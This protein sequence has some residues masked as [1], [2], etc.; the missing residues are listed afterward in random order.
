MK[1]TSLFHALLAAFLLTASVRVHAVD[2]LYDAASTFFNPEDKTRLGIEVE[3]KGLSPEASANEVARVL[4]G[5]VGTRTSTIKTDIKGYGADGKPIYNEF[6]STQYVVKDSS[7]GDVVLK[8]ETNQI[9]DV[10]KIDYDKMIVELIT[11]PIQYPQVEKLEDALKGLE[12]IGAKGTDRYTAVS[13]QVNM[14]M[15][16]GRREDVSV[17]KIL[18]LM[19]A[20][21]RPEHKAQIDAHLKV[22]ALRK[23]YVS[24][25]SDG[26]MKKLLDP[27]YKPTE[28][29]LF[30]DF[31]YRQSMERL[32]D[33]KAWTDPL[34]KVQARFFAHPN[35][36]VPSVVKQNSLRVSSL[37]MWMFP[38]DPVTHLIHDAGWAVP[39]PL[40]EFREWNNTFTAAEPARQA[41]GLKEAAYKYGYFDHDSL[42]QELTG[43]D[44]KVLPK[45]RRHVNADVAKGQPTTFRYYLGDPA[46][47][48][49]AEYTMHTRQAYK[50]EVVGFLN[51][52]GYGTKSLLIPGESVVMHRRPYHRYSVMGK[53]NPGLINANIAQVLE[54]KYAEYRFFNEYAPGSMSRT[55]I[56]SDLT[57]KSKNVRKVVGKLNEKFPK[58]WVLKGVWDLGSEKDIITDKVDVIGEVEKYQASDFDVYRNELLSDKAL[59][60]AA[61]EYLNSE[62]KKHPG[63]KGWKLSQVF[64][65]PE[66]S[67]VQERVN[68]KTE[69]RVEALAGK[70]LGGGSTVDRYSY[71]YLLNDTAGEYK[72]PPKVDVKKVEQFAQKVLDQL[73][74]NLRGMPMGMDIALLEDGTAVMI[75]SNPGGNS[76]FLYEEFEESAEELAKFLKQ[77]PAQVKAGRVHEGLSPEEQMKW[78]DQKFKDWGIHP[79]KQY[80]GFTFLKDRVQDK[81]FRPSPPNPRNYDLRHAPCGLVETIRGYLAPVPALV[82]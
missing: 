25:Y 5:E 9:D 46:T 53:Y 33:K 24:S 23:P 2:V 37:L 80:P 64:K 8:L 63:Y 55:E 54:N 36:I 82:K 66:L 12:R 40:V 65:K 42:M 45:L 51:A 61:P 56:L 14:E 16:A 22:P 34:K 28:R 39:R 81:E 48:E 18:D 21:L 38:D 71:V 52:N 7:I 43:M 6:T 59:A 58:G 30:D 20:Y 3:F 72:A 41:L 10:G 76:N 31:F 27:Q 50:G 44:G 1:R 68:I 69:F 78:I 17:P 32:G 74:E 15:F 13:T 4:G 79:A 75:E 47:V 57:D 49:R 67:M 77:Y 11:E 26:F 60:D 70:V 73:P 19:R 35:P 29:E 62:L